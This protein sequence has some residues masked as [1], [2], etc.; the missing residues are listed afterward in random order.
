M[1]LSIELAEPTMLGWLT[2]YGLDAEYVRS[3]GNTLFAKQSDG[4][5]RPVLD[6][7][8]GYGSVLLGH[9]HPELVALARELF[10]Q[11]TPI[12]AQFSRHPYANDLANRLN[13]IL[14]R[15][16]GVSEPYYAV[17][18]NSGAEAIEAAVKHAELDR[19]YKV[20]AAVEAAET[21][22]D[23]ARAAVAAGATVAEDVYRALDVPQGDFPALLAEVSRVNAELATRQPVFLSLESGF[24]GKLV[25]SVQLTHN[26]TYRTPF[27]AL[28][29]P[30]RFVPF[31]Q[32]GTVRKVLDEERVSLH[33]LVV[34]D[35][36]VR[37]AERELPVVTAFL[38][39]PIQG[40]GG[41]RELSAEFAREIA[42]ACEEVG[43]PVV[44]DEVQSGM[45]RTGAF[46]ASSQIGLRG[47]YYALSKSL[48]GGV[49]KA[50]VM[51]VRE[52]FYRGDFELVHSSTF[53]KD[54]FSTTIAGKVLD[55]LEADDG[56]AYRRAAE[57]GDQL[58]AMLESIR[59]DHPDL[60]KEVRGR[61]LMLGL[62]F[63][64]QS[65]SPSPAIAEQATAGMLGYAI[66]GFLLREHAIRTF[67]TASA[68]NTLRFEP[69]LQLTD[70]EITRLETGLRAAVEVLR[71]PSGR[72]V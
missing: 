9:N 10:A 29:R 45:G 18:A 51:L 36:V 56:R 22:L 55:L 43:V 15:E 58:T 66:A 44:I 47:D 70:E 30:S 17:F 12:H 46:F 23:E 16:F 59:A 33:E 62:E 13:T 2:A 20:R 54:S 11:G 48:G 65:A 61:G 67:P 5:E 28:A 26:P 35:G 4:S 14:H 6:F 24:H 32:P 42:E 40:E 34:T 57:L 19:V 69:S 52:K 39:E 68:T 3:S 1:N 37:L 38:L 53:A 50:A 63:H 27:G 60:V 71:S 41:I 25:G 72:L 49:A 31:N 8:G 64:D 7:A 21:A